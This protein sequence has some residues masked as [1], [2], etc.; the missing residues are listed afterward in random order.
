MPRRQSAPSH[1]LTADPVAQIAGFPERFI[2]LGARQSQCAPVIR[3]GPLKNLAEV[4]LLCATASPGDIIKRAIEA[5]RWMRSPRFEP[6]LSRFFESDDGE[7]RPRSRMCFSTQFFV[8]GAAQAGKTSH[9]AT[10]KLDEVAMIAVRSH[11]ASCR[12]SFNF[13]FGVRDSPRV[14]C[15]E[16]PPHPDH[17]CDAIRPRPA[18]GERAANSWTGQFDR[19]PI[20]PWNSDFEIRIIS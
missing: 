18:C 3:R 1:G 19:R 7:R 20:E 2:W 6:V 9:R 15:A 11:L 8:S 14:R 13:P 10:K 4:S 5:R 16:S 12:S 17:I